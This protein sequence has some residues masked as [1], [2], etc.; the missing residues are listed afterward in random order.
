MTDFRIA[1]PKYLPRLVHAWV[2]ERLVKL[3][4]RQV[5]TRLDGLLNNAATGS[6]SYPEF[7][8]ALRAEAT[9]AKE[10]KRTVMGMQIAHFPSVKTLADFDCALR[11]SVDKKL[12]DELATGRFVPHG[13]DV[14]LCGPPG[15]GESELAI[16]L[17]RKVVEAGFSVLFTSAMGL[18]RALTKASADNVLHHERAAGR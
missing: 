1:P 7:L 9:D 15:V 17:G 4:L 8:D 14:L 3:R 18:L 6:N 5:A 11:P 12:V 2:Q 10:L 16:G 13:Y